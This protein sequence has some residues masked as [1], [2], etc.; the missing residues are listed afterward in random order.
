M[1]VIPHGHA[2][3]GVIEALK[4]NET[5]ALLADRE[6]STRNDY[7]DFFAKPA[8]LP[9]GPAW[10]AAR[11]GA[12]IVHFFMLREPDDTFLMRFYPPI[13][14]AQR[15]GME[16]VR[17]QIRDI[18]EAEIGNHPEQWYIF[19]SFWQNGVE[20]VPEGTPRRNEAGRRAS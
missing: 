12:P 1:K 6:F 20:P 8:R 16:K 11:T 2:V 7:V 10:L 17:L 14:A 18:L 3:R 19:D 4:R 13:V 9:R 15:E 5:V